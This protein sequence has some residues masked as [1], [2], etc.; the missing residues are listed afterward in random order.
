M[1][2]AHIAQPNKP[3]ALEGIVKAEIGALKSFG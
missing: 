2:A 1:T 3:I